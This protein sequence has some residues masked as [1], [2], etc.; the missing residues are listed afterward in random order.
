[1]AGFIEFPGPIVFKKIELLKE[2]TLALWGTMTAQHML[3][4]LLLPLKFS[5]GVFE[6]PVV[7]PL[8]KLEKTKR[9]MLLSDAPFKR[10]FQAPFIGPGLQA[11]KYKSLDESKLALFKEIEA[12]LFYWKENPNSIFAHPIFGSLN[13]KEWYLFHS[14]HFTHHLS[15]FGLV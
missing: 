7:T 15:Q 13:E 6:V 12:F 5:R 3:E 1:M 14:K 8:D 4:H 10:D 2:D 9:I 11:L